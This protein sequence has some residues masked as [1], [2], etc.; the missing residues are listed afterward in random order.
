MTKPVAAAAAEGEEL[1]PV[2]TPAAAATAA[3]ALAIRGVFLL[4]IAS[5]D[6]AREGGR[7]FVDISV[8]KDIFRTNLYLLPRLT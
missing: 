2:V 7:R 6:M 1:V 4:D 3:A 5:I 8:E